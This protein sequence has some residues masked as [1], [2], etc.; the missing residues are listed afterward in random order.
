MVLKEKKRD[1][2]K[3]VKVRLFSDI[4][5]FAVK[6]NFNGNHRRFKRFEYITIQQKHV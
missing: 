2:L 1:A 4:L 5:N 6:Q 3:E